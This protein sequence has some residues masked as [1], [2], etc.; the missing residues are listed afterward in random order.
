MASVRE[1]LAPGT[2]KAALASNTPTLAKSLFRRACLF[3]VGGL[4]HAG[5]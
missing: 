2:L 4:G 5:S 1:Q 3:S